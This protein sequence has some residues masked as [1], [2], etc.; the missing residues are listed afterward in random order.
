MLTAMR[1]GIDSWVVKA[2][3]FLLVGS[4]GLWGIGDIFRGATDVTL[5]VIG[6]DKITGARFLPVF[7][8]RLQSLQAQQES[9]ILTTDMARALGLDQ[10]ILR[11]IVA[12]SAFDQHLNG[13]KL[14]AAR[15]DVATRIRALPVFQ[16]EFGAFDR[17]KYDSLLMAGGAQAKFEA[18]A[19][20][21]LMSD[22]LLATLAQGMAPP[23]LMVD[24]LYRF[25]GEKRDV[26]LATIPYAKMTVQEPTAAELEA[27]HRD[28]PRDF[29][30]PEYRALTYLTVAPEDLLS[31]VEVSEE[32]LKEAY[33]DRKR[34][35]TVEELRNVD[36]MVL[37]DEGAAGAAHRRLVQGAD[38]AGLAKELTGASEEDI[39]LGQ[40]PRGGFLPEAVD[41]I[42]GA[43]EGTVTEPQRSPFGWHIYRI[44]KVFEGAVLTLDEARDRLRRDVALERARDSLYGLYTAIEDELGGGSTLEE[45]GSN[46]ALR[47]SKIAAVDATGLDPAGARPTALPDHSGFLTT[48]FAMEPGLEAELPETESGALFFLRVDGVTPATLR[49]F[50][51]VRAPVTTAWR[52]AARA[53]AAG[54]AAQAMA[55]KIRL[56]VDMD[57]SAKGYEVRVVRG[58]AREGRNRGR[59]LSASA[60]VSLFD[61]DLGQTISGVAGDGSGA[62]V[63]TVTKITAAELS[64][65]EG[66]RAR[67]EAQL[68]STAQ[69]DL[70]DQY[71]NALFQDLGLETNLA[72]LDILF[73]GSGIQSSLV[74]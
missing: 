30:A 41:A 52:T 73:E 40:N 21:E 7:Q 39:A 36:Q 6:S 47:I 34:E 14:A 26:K 24:Q 72:G 18:D 68:E 32:D 46:L 51:T 33:E 31:E 4:F 9:N 15:Q 23:K 22:Q 50:S 13:L 43:P 17:L 42:F 64:G 12:R 3:L 20:S 49:P 58:L 25:R 27:Y 71:Q 28:N 10:Q 62:I 70:V 59:Y 2:L 57:E 19:A 1:K 11:Q 74:R 37:P 45:A 56:G 67:V 5:A 53:K 66:E 44:N 35:F 63:A 69:T 8:N 55:D 60:V 54:K 48:A 65:E 38:F 61:L 16:N 29:T